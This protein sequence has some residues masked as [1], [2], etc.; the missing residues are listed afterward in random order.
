MLQG[1]P[2]FL[3]KKS[4]GLD[5]IVLRFPPDSRSRI[6]FLFRYVT[7][8]CNFEYEENFRNSMNPFWTVKLV[9]WTPLN[10][11]PPSPPLHPAFSLLLY[12]SEK[13]KRKARIKVWNFYIVWIFYMSEY[14][15]LYWFSIM[16]RRDMILLKQS[17]W[18]FNSAFLWLSK[19][20]ANWIVRDGFIKVIA[21]VKILHR[22]HSFRYSDQQPLLENVILRISFPNFPNFWPKRTRD[23]V[24]V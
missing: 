19:W 18:I 15:A 11:E 7:F 23:G 6:Y 17:V 2:N 12:F 14:K 5:H 3:G 13:E 9:T 16:R 20:I 1:D 4:I 24:L 22:C 10:N 21:L 8:Q